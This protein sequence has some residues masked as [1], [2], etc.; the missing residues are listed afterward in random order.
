MKL[1]YVPGVCSLASHIALRE[2][3]AEFQLDKVD[4]K[5][6]ITESGVNYNQLNPKSYVPALQLDDGRVLPE[7]ASVL[8]YLAD[9]KGA[10]TAAPKPGTKERYK[11]DAMPVF[12][13]TEVPKNFSP[14]FRNTPDPT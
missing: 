10:E 8:L 7:G 11:R 12:N 6:K 13:D 14:L 3:G 5:T 2:M 4:R 1:Y 9:P